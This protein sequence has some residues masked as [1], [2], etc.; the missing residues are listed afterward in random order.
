MFRSIATTAMIF[1]LSGAAA[2]AAEPVRLDKVPLDRTPLKTWGER[3]YRYQ[4]DRNGEVQTLGTVQLTTHLNGDRVTFQDRWQLKVR[5][6]DIRLDMTVETDDS[7]WMRPTRVVA[8]GEGDDEVGRFTAQFKADHALL[9]RADKPERKV[10][11]PADTLTD[12]AMMR[13]FTMMPRKAGTAVRVGHVLELSEMNLKGEAI[14]AYTG[15][16]NITIAGKDEALH[17]FTYTR[18]ERTVLEA[19]VSDKGALRRMKIDDRKIITDVGPDL[20]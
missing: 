6:Q 11:V 17:R 12:A 1:A 19:W 3:T 8:D 20:L 16:Q 18:G 14:I 13:L 2:F 4:I 5:G 9:A 15:K 10:D 7:P